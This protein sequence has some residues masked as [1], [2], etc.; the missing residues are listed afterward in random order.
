MVSFKLVGD[1]AK[2][3][4]NELMKVLTPCK[5]T[6]YDGIMLGQ[7]IYTTPLFAENFVCPNCQSKECYVLLHQTKKFL[8]CASEECV[9]KNA[10]RARKWELPRLTPLECGIIEELKDAN[11][12]QCSQ[13]EEIKQ[14]TKDFINKKSGFCLLAG[15]PGRGK[16]YLAACMLRLY[17]QNE[18]D[19]LFVT[20]GDLYQE[21][22][23]ISSK[24]HNVVNLLE[25]LQSKKLLILDDLGSIKITDGFADFLFM[26]VDKRKTK[27]SL[28]TVITTNFNSEQ[29]NERLG[30]PVVS[31]LS[32]GLIIKIDGDDK[33]RSF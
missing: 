6:N 30:S 17:L 1:I 7:L 29:L 13:S 25:K 10:G 23:D 8:S 22:L 24:G 9:L 2:G 33:R 12:S 19:A 32:T 20:H 11:Y 16:T 26:L 15:K 18:R 27:P 31:R 3:Q 14:K 5:F 4:L 21:W 28:A